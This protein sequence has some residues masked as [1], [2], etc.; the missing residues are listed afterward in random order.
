MSVDVIPQEK[1]AENSLLYAAILCLADSEEESLRPEH[2]AFFQRTALRLVSHL[3]S[4]SQV[5]L[6]LIAFRA[7]EQ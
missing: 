6:V 2:R 5:S 3:I 1:K 4:Q 7:A